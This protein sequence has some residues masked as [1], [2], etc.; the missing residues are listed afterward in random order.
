MYHYHFFCEGQLHRFTR[1]LGNHNFYVVF[2]SVFTIQD[3]ENEITENE[4]RF[5]HL[6]IVFPS[7][8]VQMSIPLT[9]NKFKNCNSDIKLNSDK[10]KP[11]ELYI[12]SGMTEN[13]LFSSFN[14]H[15]LKGGI[16]ILLNKIRRRM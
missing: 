16:L 8:K 3:F 1:C 11:H 2:E 6:V 9:S 13:V 5:P 7:R 12:S 4:K 14:L 10:S 15:F